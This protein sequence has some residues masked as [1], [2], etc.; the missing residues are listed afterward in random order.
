MK[1]CGKTLIEVKKVMGNK[2][3]GNQSSSNLQNLRTG[4]V[5]AKGEINITSPQIGP[6]AFPLGV[7]HKQ[8]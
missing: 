3:I 5:T 4:I 1:K 2:S 8:P 6:L 7:Y